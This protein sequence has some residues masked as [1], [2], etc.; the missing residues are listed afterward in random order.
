MIVS[1]NISERSAMTA[2]LHKRDARIVSIAAEDTATNWI[3][4]A[5]TAA[6]AEQLIVR[7]SD[8]LAGRSDGAAQ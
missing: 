2:K 8:A 3:R 1:I 4:L 5:M 6:Q 7:L